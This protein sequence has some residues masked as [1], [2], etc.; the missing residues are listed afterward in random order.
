MKAKYYTTIIFVDHFTDYT[1]VHLMQDMTDASTLE[2][3]HAYEA[4]IMY[5][6][7]RFMAYHADNGRYAEEAFHNDTDDKMQQLSF[8]G[9]GEHSQNRIAERCIKSLSEDA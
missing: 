8:C 2:A 9:V 5:H 3:K 7:H 4:L 1:Y 6:G